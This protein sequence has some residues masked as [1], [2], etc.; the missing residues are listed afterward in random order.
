[1]GNRIVIGIL[2]LLVI[3]SGG[4]SYYSFTLN[5]Q[6]DNLG[7]RLSDFETEQAAQA[8]RVNEKIAGLRQEMSSGLD[9]LEQSIR[10]TGDDI[11][12]LKS[13][14]QAASNRINSIDDAAVDIASQVE[15]LNEWVAA[16][17]NI[18]TS[19]IDARAVYIKTRISVVRITNGQY[20]AG[21][22]VLYDTGGHVLTAAHVVDGLAQIYVVLH[23]GRV[24]RATVVGSCA[25]SDIAVLK[26][27][28]N[29]GIIPPQLADSSLLKVGEPV[30]ALGSP[31]EL[32]DTLTVGVV[33][34]L[35]RYA[36]IQYD[37]ESRSIPNLIQFDAPVNAGNSGCPLM[38]AAGEVIGIVI[39]RLGASEGDGIY[40]A[41]SSNKA[42]LVADELIAN[43]S[44]DYPWIGIGISDLTP[45][46]VT[47]LYL[48][49][50]NGVLVGDILGDPAA[51]AGIRSGDIII[52]F[53]GKRITDMAGLTSYVGENVRPGDRVSIDVLRGGEKK[54]LVLETGTRE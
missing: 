42:R 22:G 21:S 47:E 40:Y 12:A 4:I 25:L 33:S 43:G 3:I 32:K 15:S 36:S 19:V 37:S 7:Q 53:D 38:N 26:L 51:D 50:A 44:F 45:Q 54:T 9:A 46:L 16:A 35:N 18:T 48:D 34:Q 6:L 30:A 13:G 28:N 31:F 49:D 52:S 2:V 1:M 11:D 17:E 27:T 8:D 5:R 20:T 41:V 29:P 14:L 10:E 24:S 23:D 39:A